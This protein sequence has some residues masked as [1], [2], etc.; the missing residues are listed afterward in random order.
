MRKKFNI[1]FSLAVFGLMIS[2][3]PAHATQKSINNLSI[4]AGSASAE[5]SGLREDSTAALA[6]Y[7]SRMSVP[8]KARITQRLGTNYNGDSW[9]NLTV[10]STF[11]WSNAT[12]K[13]LDAPILNINTVTYQ[14]NTQT[15]SG[16]W[17]Y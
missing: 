14:N 3:V 11:N 17:W 4:P 12:V 1:L 2:V 7:T 8:M 5:V 9:H 10:N 16:I 15:Y 13:R 6:L